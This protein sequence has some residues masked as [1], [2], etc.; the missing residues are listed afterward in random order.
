[1]ARSERSACG[2]AGFTLVELLVVI[3][4]IGILL[5]LLVPGLL[6]IRANARKTACGNN[7]NQ[8]VTAIQQDYLSNAERGYFPGYINPRDHTWAIAIFSGLGEADLHQKW[9]T[10]SGPTV[11]RG[12]FLCPDDEQPTEAPLS[13]VVN[14]GLRGDDP[15]PKA[16]GLFHDRRA[17]RQGPT[18]VSSDVVDGAQHTLMLSERTLTANNQIIN[19]QWI[20]KSEILL[21]F[22]FEPGSDGSIEPYLKSSHPG[23]VMV[24]FCDNSQ[25]F[26]DENIDYEIYELLMTPNGRKIGQTGTLNEGDY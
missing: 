22:H 15:E 3:V 18:V 19:R 1:M 21:G 17:G 26:I 7:L 12:V 8:L 23:G 24:S 13:Y 10:G 2:R 14:A 20:D 9:R 5:G 4:I 6:S 16:T 11:L 25:E